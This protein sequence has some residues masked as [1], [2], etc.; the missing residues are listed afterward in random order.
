MAVHNTTA[1]SFGDSCGQSIWESICLSFYP[2]PHIH[3]PNNT[4]GS[5]LPM[6]SRM[7]DTFCQHWCHAMSPDPSCPSLSTLPWYLLFPYVCQNETPVL[8]YRRFHCCI[9][10]SNITWIWYNKCW[11]LIT[12]MPDVL[13]VVSL[14]IGSTFDPGLLKSNIIRNIFC[15]HCWGW[16]VLNRNTY[17]T[18]LGFVLL[19][20]LYKLDTPLC[21][22][23]E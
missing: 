15:H 11:Y 22:W 6:K 18:G 12:E 21:N 14:M 16:Q 9:F 5:M 10:I 20:L 8:N 1:F 3:P 2:Y 19:C 13:I 17:P 23:M 4:F 7:R